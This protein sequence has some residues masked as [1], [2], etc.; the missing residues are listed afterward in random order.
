[1]KDSKVAKAASEQFQNL[2]ESKVGE[3]VQDAYQNA[4]ET[5]M[6]EESKG[7]KRQDTRFNQ[8]RDP[9]PKLN[10]GKQESE[11]GGSMSEQ[12]RKFRE[13]KFKEKFA[14]S[15]KKSDT[16]KRQFSTAIKK[17]GKSGNYQ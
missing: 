10:Q 5:I 3:K 6:G 13:M 12:D 8:E 14:D 17:E 16:D 2:K 11:L 15:S 4:K 1:M 7:D 9:D